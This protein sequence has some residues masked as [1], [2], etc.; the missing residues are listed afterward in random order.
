M[1]LDLTN[2]IFDKAQAPSILMIG[3][4]GMGKTYSLRKLVDLGLEV[5][6]LATDPGIE[7]ILGD[8]PQEKC[9][10]K[11]IPAFGSVNEDNPFSSLLDSAKLL[12]TETLDQI[13]KRG[14]V[15][16]QNHQQYWQVIDTCNDFVCDRTGQSY[17]NVAKWDCRRVFV[18][19]TLSGLTNMAIR[20]NIGDKPFMELRDYSAA[21]FLIRQFLNIVASR[22][23]AWFICNS[24]L[25]R[26]PDPITGLN[27]I[28]VSTTGKAL[29]PEVPRFFSDSIF[30]RRTI[31]GGKPTYLWD[32]LN[33]ECTTK[34][35]NLPLAEN[36][37]ATLEPLVNNWVKKILTGAPVPGV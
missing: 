6:V 21:Q 14:G 4:M 32:T 34:S 18:L 37:P 20:N 35:R 27:K 3:E 25:E 10:W 8:L 33:G 29:S 7:D 2:P 31:S 22:T 15:N 1:P 28:M 19:D 16:K 5:F 24:H 9:H 12:N 30:L 26:E 17:G 23:N 13:Q 11:Y 36:L